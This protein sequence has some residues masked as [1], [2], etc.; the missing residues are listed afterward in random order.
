VPPH[1]L[2][3]TLRRPETFKAGQATHLAVPWAFHD[4]F[5]LH[6]LTSLAGSPDANIREK[7]RLT[8]QIIVHYKELIVI[9]NNRSSF[10]VNIFFI[11]PKC[12]YLFDF[13]I[14]LF[15]KKFNFKIY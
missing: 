9:D 12:F 13:I 1:Q 4:F 15:I 5:D 6:S 10:P 3:V 8:R 2:G 7:S 11:N 14:I